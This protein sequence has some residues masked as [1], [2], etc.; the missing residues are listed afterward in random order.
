MGGKATRAELQR[1]AQLWAEGR[2]IAEIGEIM[3]RSR[4]AI[5]GYAHRNRDLFGPRS[6]SQA[7]E[8]KVSV[9]GASTIARPAASEAKLVRPHFPEDPKLA[10]E[11]HRYDLDKH[12]LPGITPVPFRDLESGQCKFAL[13][14]VHQTCGPDTPFCAAPTDGGPYCPAH[15]AV[16]YVKRGE[17][18]AQ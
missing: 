8:L 2:S 13:Q 17:G 18:E 12:A 7:P 15:R 11:A 4:S 14:P 10:L 6:Q 3:G 9:A 1:M 16:V 5:C